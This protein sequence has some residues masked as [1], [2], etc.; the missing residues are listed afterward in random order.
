MK[1][2]SHKWFDHHTFDIDTH[3]FYLAPENGSMGWVVPKRLLVLSAPGYSD[4]PLLFDMLPLFRKWHINTV[5]NFNGESRGFEDLIRVGIQHISLECQL[6]A[7]PQISEVMKFIEI[8]DKGETIAIASLNGLGRAPMFAAIWLVHS[9]GFSPKEAIA[10]VRTVKQGAIYGIQQDFVVRM[11]RV[12]H[13]QVP[14]SIAIDKTLI[15]LVKKN[16]K[17]TN[18][19]KTKLHTLKLTYA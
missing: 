13:P 7:L 8:C 9:F 14:Q 4:S 10:W 6:D 15:S 17:T 16:K 11:E 12:F 5:V 1:A 3:N 19:E 2:V 18:N